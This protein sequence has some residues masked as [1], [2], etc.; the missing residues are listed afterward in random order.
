MNCV[1]VCDENE[2]VQYEHMPYLDRLWCSM[3]MMQVRGSSVLLVVVEVEKQVE[4]VIRHE[5]ILPCCSV[6]HCCCCFGS[7]GES[8]V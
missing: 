6:A 2:K 5:L 1:R 3:G 7:L 8:D 4:R